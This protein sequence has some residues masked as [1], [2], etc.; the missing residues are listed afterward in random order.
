MSDASTQASS[1]EGIRTS[2]EIWILATAQ[3]ISSAGNG[4][5][6]LAIPWFVLTTTDRPAKTGIVAASTAAAGVVA[7][8]LGGAAI[9]RLGFQRTSVLSDL[10]SVISV[11]MI[12]V[13]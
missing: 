8:L 4:I 5:A 7:G 11:L 9:D 6:A 10:L 3:G 13:L 1:A 2:S 12:P